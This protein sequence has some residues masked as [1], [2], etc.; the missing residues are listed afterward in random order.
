MSKNYVL[1]L[2]APLI[3]NVYHPLRHELPDDI[4]LDD[5][6]REAVEYGERYDRTPHTLFHNGKVYDFTIDGVIR[7]GGEHHHISLGK[8]HNPYFNGGKRK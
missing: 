1:V 2:R 7:M 3:L 5:A 4:S 8:V 6:I